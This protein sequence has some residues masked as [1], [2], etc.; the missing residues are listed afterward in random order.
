MFCLY[1]VKNYKRRFGRLLV[2]ENEI[3]LP[4]QPTHYRVFFKDHGIK[5]VM[6]FRTEKH[7][8]SEV[9]SLRVFLIG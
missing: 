1:Q 8:V 5:G 4:S 6:P 9:L 2:M 7:K 3:W